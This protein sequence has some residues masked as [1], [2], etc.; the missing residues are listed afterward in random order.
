MAGNFRKR[1]N[2][3]LMML[4]VCSIRDYSTSLMS[5]AVD[6]SIDSTSV[7]PVL[8]HHPIMSRLKMTRYLQLDHTVST[9]STIMPRQH[10]ADVYSVIYPFSSLRVTFCFRC[11]SYRISHNLFTLHYAGCLFFSL[12]TSPCSK[13][14]FYSVRFCVAV[15]IIYLWH[16]EGTENNIFIMTNGCWI[17][18]KEIMYY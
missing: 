13:Y 4:D 17:K 3:I 5:S 15:H 6:S 18:D 8:A 7:S 11:F 14:L 10:P 16:R 9:A 2:Y 1:E 12:F